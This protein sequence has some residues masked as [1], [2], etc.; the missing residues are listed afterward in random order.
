MTIMPPPR[1][2]HLTPW[3]A[4]ALAAIFAAG[5]VACGSDDD[6]PSSSTGALTLRLTD[7]PVDDA[8]EVV[9]VFTGMELQRRDGARRIV[10]LAAPRAIDLLQ[11]SDGRTT[12]LVEGLAVEAGDYE[13][14]RLMITAEQ[15]LQSGSYIR[16]RDGRQ[17]PL[18]MPSGAETGLK[19]QRRFTVAQGSVT[20]LV[21]DFDLRK[22]VVAPPGQAPNWI[23]R[24][25]LRLLDELQVGRIEGRV[26]L[27]ALAALQGRS[28][29]ACRP[30][31]YLF[32]G[33]GAEPDDMDGIATDGA[34]PVVYQ[35]LANDGITTTVPYAI[36]F[37]EAGAYTIAATC[38]YDVDASPGASEYD[39]T[40]AAP[41]PGQ[42]AP[43]GYQT[44]A[45]SRREV[46]VSA[47]QTAV[48]DLP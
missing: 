30:G 46:S 37:V 34:D 9:V 4:C 18:Y 44:M 47:G 14:I 36:P 17:F 26:D 10:M 12:N 3:A 1:T 23:L 25:A 29:A 31:L 35:G 6:R 45:W 19:L 39:P 40:A 41:L 38:D 5:V 11:L 22:S 28:R 21:I 15:N 16:L 33:A 48:A 32:S 43:P 24:P 42:V 13:G 2:G 8:A 20:R 7:A 27:S